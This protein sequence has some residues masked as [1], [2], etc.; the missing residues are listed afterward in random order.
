MVNKMEKVQ[1]IQIESLED[2]KL[3]HRYLTAEEILMYLSLYEDGKEMG[4]SFVLADKPVGERGYNILVVYRFKGFTSVG[5]EED[6]WNVIYE[7][8]I[9]EVDG[10]SAVLLNHDGYIDDTSTQVAMTDRKLAIL[11]K[12]LK[13]TY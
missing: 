10:D 13:G 2:I 7:A 11:C 4:K 9:H 12:I 1:A 3:H 5:L 8:W 6:L